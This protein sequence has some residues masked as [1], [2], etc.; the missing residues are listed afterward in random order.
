MNHIHFKILTETGITENKDINY[1]SLH[2]FKQIM[3][4]IDL[5]SKKQSISVMFSYL[6]RVKQTISLCIL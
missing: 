1:K 3:F 4:M 5:H 6:R 2:F